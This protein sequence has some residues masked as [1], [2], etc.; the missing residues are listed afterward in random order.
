MRKA[1]IVVL[2]ISVI[3]V[4]ALCGCEEKTSNETNL[5]DN[6]H[7]D[8]GG[9]FRLVNGSL[10]FTTNKSGGIVSAEVTMMFQNILNRTVSANITVAFYDKNDTQLYVTHRQFYDYP[11]GYRDQSVLPAN[12]VTYNGE[13]ANKVDHVVIT[14]REIKGL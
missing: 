9:I 8:G 5:F 14:V 12:I 2:F 6:I 3:A 4:A 10:S 13:N 1:G 7:F 11:P